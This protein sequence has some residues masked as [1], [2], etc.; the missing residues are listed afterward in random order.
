MSNI[1]SDKLNGLVGKMLG[2]LGGAFSVPTATIGY[3][4]GL[5]EALHKHGAA[6][7]DKLA[8][9]TGLARRYVREWAL[10]QAANGYISFHP[11][12]DEFVR[13]PEQEM[14][15]AIKDSPVYL[16][17]AFDL[18]AEMVKGQPKVQ[19]AFKTGEGVAWGESSGCMVCAVGAFFRP[20]YVNSIGQ[21][22]LA[23]LHVLEPKLQAGAKVA[24]VSRGVGF[25]RLLMGEPLPKS[26][27]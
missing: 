15:F 14:V 23:A 3:K 11:G 7:A 9:R 12:T 4:L 21:A 1:D 16:E 20:S 6:T 27:L 5:F 19:N 10:A 22:L 8:A 26:S 17:G 25:S 18:A 2:D 13:S 24:E